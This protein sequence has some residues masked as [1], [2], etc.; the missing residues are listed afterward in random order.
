MDRFALWS[1]I[2]VLMLKWRTEHYTEFN[3]LL[4]LSSCQS[5]KGSQTPQTLGCQWCLLQPR[6]MSHYNEPEWSPELE[7][8]VSAESAMLQGAHFVVLYL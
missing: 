3:K 2:V 7:N 6:K 1:I 4:N 5:L 8:Q